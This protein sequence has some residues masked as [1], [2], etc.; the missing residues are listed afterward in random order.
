MFILKPTLH[1]NFS[2]VP[3]NTLKTTRMGSVVTITMSIVNI[4]LKNYKKSCYVLPLIKLIIQWNRH[5]YSNNSRKINLNNFL[6]LLSFKLFRYFQ[7]N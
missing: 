6:I 3:R 7:S 2:F 5:N 1:L 4:I